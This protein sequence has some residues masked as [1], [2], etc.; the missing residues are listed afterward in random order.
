MKPTPEQL[1]EV[2]RETGLR[3]FLHGVS[4]T[5]ARDLLGR[6]VE[7]LRVKFPGSRPELELAHGVHYTERK[8]V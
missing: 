2:A 7:A 1:L 3:C 4:A 8:L 5:D 6:F